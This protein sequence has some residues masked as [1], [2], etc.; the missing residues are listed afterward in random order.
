M[1]LKEGGLKSLINEWWHSVEIRGSGSFVLPEKLKALK[2]KLGK[3]NKDSFRRVKERK[4]ASLRK[5]KD[6]DSLEVTRLLSLRERELKMEAFDEFKH[7][8]LLEETY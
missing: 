2:I 4:K 7:C 6:W 3:W 1:W 5:V 8:T